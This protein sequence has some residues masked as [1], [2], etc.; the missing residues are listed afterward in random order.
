M[1]TTFAVLFGAVLAGWWLPRR[2]ARIDLRHTDPLPVLVSWLLAMGGF[3]LVG[4]VGVALLLVP[5][6]GTSGNL[7]E[8][9]HRC[10]IALQHG[11][12]PEIEELG[13]VLG[14]VLLTA[15][16]ARLLVIGLRVSRRLWR[17]RREQRAILRLAG[18]V[19]EHAPDTLWLAHDRPL[20][21]SI[22][23][24]PGLV[25]ATEGLRRLGDDV[26]AAV[27]AHER[28][29]LRGRH[30]LLVAVVDILAQWLPFVPLFRRAPAAIAELVELAADVDAVRFHGSAAVRSALLGVAGGE[31]PHGALAMA[32]DA[33][34]LRLERLHLAGDA[35]RGA[36]RALSCGFAGIA[37]A[38]LPF[39]A[40]ATVMLSVA[41][42][43]CPGVA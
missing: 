22:A 6:H 13:G 27:L 34:R 30:H 25:V 9:L 10:W 39:V 35:P 11:S 32:R 3:L 28:S 8:L 38:S 37:A 29:H 21:F 12:A 19:E 4:A 16:L 7:A 14:A 1:T 20:A 18:R 17:G 24:R 42:V 26:A 23:G 31:T 2:L 40:G 43:A 36:R 41:V 15:G 5:D 33:V